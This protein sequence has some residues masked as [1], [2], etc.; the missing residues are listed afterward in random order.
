[1]IEQRWQ[2]NWK[3]L[4]P[5]QESVLLELLK[6]T[7]WLGHGPDTEFIA[8]PHQHL[9]DEGYLHVV[10]KEGQIGVPFRWQT[11]EM[12]IELGFVH[13]SSK[14]GNYCL[15]QDAWEYRDWQRLPRP[16]RFLKAQW[17]MSRNEVRAA[18]IS[19]IV[20]LAVS[21]VARLL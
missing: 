1:M 19:A 7:N 18:V 16:F 2:M 13:Q 20:S 10:G 9:K 5:Y 14:T 8:I 6:Q 11:L 4:T 12:L 15:H 3:R 17:A 21:I